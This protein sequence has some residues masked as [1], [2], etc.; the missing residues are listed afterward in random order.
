LY[1]TKPFRSPRCGL[2]FIAIFLT[3]AFAMAYK[4]VAALR[5]TSK[6]YSFIMSLASM[7]ALTHRKNIC[8]KPKHFDRRRY[9]A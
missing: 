7:L 6:L 3:M 9:A 8:V 5:L 2:F 4:Q 1:K